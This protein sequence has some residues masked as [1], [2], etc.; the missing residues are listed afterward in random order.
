MYR[1]TF[2]LG[3]KFFTFKLFFRIVKY[4]A[5]STLCGKYWNLLSTTGG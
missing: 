1:V 3:N 2:A 5:I 4:C